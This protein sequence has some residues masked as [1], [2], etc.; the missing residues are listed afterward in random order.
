MWMLF[1]FISESLFCFICECCL[2]MTCRHPWRA[3]SAVVHII[4]CCLHHLWFTSTVVHIG[5]WFTSS[6]LGSEHLWFTSALFSLSD[7]HITI[8]H[9]AE[10]F[11]FQPM[12]FKVLVL[13]HTVSWHCS[14]S[15]PVNRLTCQQQACACQQHWMSIFKERWSYWLQLFIETIFWNCQ[16]SQHE[17]RQLLLKHYKRQ[18]KSV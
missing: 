4:R 17:I 15:I 14:L 11:D 1:C 5:L 9:N 2:F 10:S 6:R 13:F 12:T 7:I 3:P 8:T 16:T 18:Q